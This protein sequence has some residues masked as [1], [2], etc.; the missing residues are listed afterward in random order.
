M[1]GGV[2]G[3][4]VCVEEIGTAVVRQGGALVLDGCPAVRSNSVR[5]PVGGGL[6]GADEVVVGER[7]AR[8]EPGGAVGQGGT[9]VSQFARAAGEV[10]AG[11]VDVIGH[12]FVVAPRSH[13][14]ASVISRTVRP[15]GGAR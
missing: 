15:T 11:V 1:A 4:V 7:Y 9:T 13:R 6:L 10:V 8:A 5:E 14:T 3:G 2:I 12:L